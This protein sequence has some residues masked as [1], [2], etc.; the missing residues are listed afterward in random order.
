ML[1]LLIAGEGIE[2]EEMKDRA[3]YL[4][5]LSCHIFPAYLNLWTKT[6]TY[7][8]LLMLIFPKDVFP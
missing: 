8:Y 7:A 1:L 5:I 3:R 6:G 4:K 2:V